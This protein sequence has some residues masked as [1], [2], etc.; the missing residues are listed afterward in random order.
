[1]KRAGLLL[2]C[3]FLALACLTVHRRSTS[4]H[5]HLSGCGR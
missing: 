5:L 1:V 4:Y 3:V 2:V